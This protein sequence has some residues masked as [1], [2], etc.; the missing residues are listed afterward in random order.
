MKKF[1]FQAFSAHINYRDQFTRTNTELRAS[2]IPKIVQT[3]GMFFQFN[4]FTSKETIP[5]VNCFNYH[6]FF[7]NDHTNYAHPVQFFNWIIFPLRFFL[8]EVEY[9]T[10]HDIRWEKEFFFWEN[11]LI[12][13]GQSWKFPFLVF[14][15]EKL[16]KKRFSWRKN[17]VNV[18]WK[19]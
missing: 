12:F 11:M 9:L 4:S 14:K 15:W 10:L 8:K 5:K 7:V 2:R 16:V 17:V 18:I 3:L 19:F 6:E 13:N 1:E